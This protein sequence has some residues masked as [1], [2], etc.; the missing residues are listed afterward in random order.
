M[1][2]IKLIVYKYIVEQILIGNFPPGCVISRRNVA[3]TLNFSISPVNE[4][5]AILHTEKIIDTIP[6]KGTFVAQLDWRD[7]SEIITVRIALEVE[8]A[9]YYCGKRLN[10][11]MTK[12]I[13]L[14][15][16][17]DAKEPS[18]LENLLA[19]VSFHRALV[20][21][22]NNKLLSSFFSLLVTRSLLLGKVAIT[23][24]RPKSNEHE[25]FL[26]KLNE[27]NPLDVDEII[28]RNI[29]VGKE[30]IFN[31]VHLQDRSNNRM[32]SL[33]IVLSILQEEKEQH[34]R[35]I[36]SV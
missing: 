24:S 9:K 10:P 6:R 12:L 8:A 15:K 34:D 11:H 18:D 26:H 7:L 33:D 25:V 2:S 31:H 3:E 30:D 4:A 17:A 27:A 35:I 22:A 20:N 19:D 28:R 36:I 23:K 29:L 5:F 21:T 14:A 16:K 1:R 32:T 13:E